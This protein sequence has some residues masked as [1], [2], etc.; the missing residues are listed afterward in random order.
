MRYALTVFLIFIKLLQIII[1]ALNLLKDLNP[2]AILLITFIKLLLPSIKP[3][4]YTNPNDL[5]YINIWMEE[6][7]PGYKMDINTLNNVWF[8][9]I[10]YL[11]YYIKSWKEMN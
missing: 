4:D 6:L 9:S 2:K 5:I 1:L 8:D 10:M 3:Y 7:I 11:K